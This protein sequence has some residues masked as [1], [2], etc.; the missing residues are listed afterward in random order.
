MFVGCRGNISREISLKKERELAEKKGKRQRN[1]GEDA[2][3]VR[4]E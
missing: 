2:S 4:R 1:G 3:M